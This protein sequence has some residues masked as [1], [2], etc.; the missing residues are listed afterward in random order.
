MNRYS[1]RA[2]ALVGPS[3]MHWAFGLVG[4]VLAYWI[5]F[6]AGDPKLSHEARFVFCVIGAIAG[7]WIWE[8]ISRLFSLLKG[9]VPRKSSEDGAGE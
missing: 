1:R 7:G 8:G 3:F 6:V 2:A 9:G 5:I 4:F